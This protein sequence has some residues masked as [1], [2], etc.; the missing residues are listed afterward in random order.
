MISFYERH[1]YI[2]NC[3]SSNRILRYLRQFHRVIT[4]FI[5]SLENVY[6]YTEYTQFF[7]NKN[8]NQVLNLNVLTRSHSFHIAYSRLTS[9]AL[10]LLLL[11]CHIFSSS[12]KI[13]FF[14]L[15]SLQLMLLQYS[16]HY[17]SSTLKIIE[18]ATTY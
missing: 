4:L 9:V 14:I 18:T 5:Y 8:N 16:S 11:E 7:I 3:R 6:N 2:E 12:F 15:F 1:V 17:I 13:N 10:L